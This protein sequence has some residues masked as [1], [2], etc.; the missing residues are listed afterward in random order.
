MA[1]G[2]ATTFETLRRIVNVRRVYYEI[3]QEVA[4]LGEERQR[5]GYELKLWA[6]HERGARALPGCRKCWD[7]VEDL[8]QIAAWLAR[9]EEPE[10][11]WEVQVFERALHDSRQFPGTD[12]IDLALRLFHRAG[13]DGA[14][15]AGQRSLRRVRRDLA[16]LGVAE[17]IWHPASAGSHGH[18]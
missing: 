5:V 8:Q 9:A 7:I 15:G 1:G 12:E 6:L 18:G 16:D 3:A 13:R 10:L 11:R 17:G 4:L 2:E 14:E